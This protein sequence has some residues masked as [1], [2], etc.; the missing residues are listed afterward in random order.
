MDDDRDAVAGPLHVE[1]DL[2]DARGDTGVE[3]RDRVLGREGGGAA[4]ADDADRRAANGSNG[5]RPVRG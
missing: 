2:I 5:C 3:G 4:M 1:L